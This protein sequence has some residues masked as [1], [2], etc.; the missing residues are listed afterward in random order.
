MERESSN[1]CSVFFLW[2]KESVWLRNRPS[3][4]STMFSSRRSA[5]C[6]VLKFNQG[7]EVFEDWYIFYSVV[8]KITFLNGNLCKYI[9]VSQTFVIDAKENYKIDGFCVEF[10]HV[11]IR[12]CLFS[13]INFLVFEYRIYSINRPGRSLNFWT[14]RVGAY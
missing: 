14:L 9:N 12:F 7:S 1:E 11:L 10:C 8:K 6:P 3:R 4:N 13:T 5:K 2:T